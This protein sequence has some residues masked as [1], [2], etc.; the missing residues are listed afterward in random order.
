MI[1]LNTYTFQFNLYDLVLVAT[2]FVGLTLSSQL[3]FKKSTHQPANRLLAMA[4]VITVLQSTWLLV[5][6]AQLITYIPLQVSLAW[7]PLIFCYV[8]K[9]SRPAY[10]FR[11]KDSLH[12]VPLCLQLIAD[13]FGTP[14][15][16]IQLLALA[17]GI[18]YL[19]L[20][21]RLIHRH[22]KGLQFNG[23]D[24]SHAQLKWLNRT[25]AVLLVLGC[26]GLTLAA[27]GHFFYHDGLNLQVYYP[28]YLLWIATMIVFTVKAETMPAA[29]P[30]ALKPLLPAA[31]KQKATWLKQMVREHHYYLDPDLSLT[32]LAEKLE[33][34]VH[35]L[36]RILN[37]V[38]KKSFSD[39][40]NEYRVR[41]V[42]RKMQDT[43]YNHL[44][45]LGIAYESGFNS[46][47]NFTRVLK[48]LTGKSPLDYKNS[49][50]KDYPFYNPDSQRSFATIILNHHQKLNRNFMLRNYFKIA[51]RNLQRHKVFSGFNIFGLATGMACSI[52]IFLWV[53]DESSFDRFNPQAEQIFRVTDQSG[54]QPAYVT[55]PPALAYAIKTQVPAIKNATRIT[56]IQKMI[57][58]GHKKF[59]QKNIFYADSSFLQIFNYPLL[60]GSAATALSAP[61]SVVL[62][63]T[64]AKKYF[65]SA[66]EAMGK[67]IYID[68]DIKGTTLLVTGIL[69]D[70]PANS[71]LQP[72]MLIPMEVYDRVNNVKFGWTNFDVFVYFQLKDGIIASPS[73]MRSVCRQ[74]DAIYKRNNREYVT[75]FSAQPLTDIHLHSHFMR[76]VPGQ[77]NAE[78]VTIF[79]LAAIFIILI[80]CINFINLATAISGQR[81][82]EVGLRKTIGA[83]RP[84]LIAQFMGESLMLSFM[85]LI[86]AIVLVFLLLPL[87]NQLADKNISFDLFRPNILLMLAGVALFT[88]IVSGSY[89]AFFLASFNPVKALKSGQVLRSNKS[90]LRNGLVV[91]QFSISI[92]LIVSTIVIYNQLQFIQHRDIGFDK[93]NLL[94]MRM[95]QVGDLK[96]NKDAMRAALAGYPEVSNF[97][98]TDQ[99]PTNLSDGV[100]SLQW[101]GMNPTTQ[102]EAYRLRVDRNFLGTFGLKV[103]AGRFFSQDFAGDDSSFVVNE[104]ALRVM[105][106]KPSD[107]VGRSI[108]FWDEKA[109]IIGVVKDFNF[110]SVQYG[111]EPLILKSNFSGGYVVMR[112]R[113]G[114]V[115]KV[116]SAIQKSFHNVYGDYPFSYGFVDADIDK[117]YITQ[118][119]M[120]KL[121]N[122]F[123]I[124]SIIISCLGLFGLA[125]FAA[126]QRIKEIGIRKVLGASE[127][128]LVALLS[129]DF[130][131][132]VLLS[133]VFAFPVAWWL[134]NA[135]LHGFAYRITVSWWIFA[136]AGSMAMLIA[137][138]TVSYQAI[139]AAQAKPVRSLRN[140]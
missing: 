76:D 40:I 30:L 55:A 28:L 69:K 29:A 33:M 138:A 94:Y 125:I 1:A 2:V 17:S 80:A 42:S 122:V 107:A 124:L 137:F 27:A 130:I 58:V 20:S 103:V 14:N 79:A 25:M 53:Q 45:L 104:A 11:L 113:A 7:G 61:N 92:I 140:E 18:T 97:T 78:Y 68:N 109:P 126:R 81:A 48:Q 15:L 4:L 12:L 26:L 37:T 91:L 84:Q 6:D 77:G 86:M 41:E 99:L 89:P 83:L 22:N 87:F 136:L 10:K 88:G 110:K 106:L 13:Y 82:K 114:T 71:H 128:S 139:K 131:R 51:W 8:L 46:Q 100:S 49:L 85:A 108:T 96:N 24:R 119:R 39:F 129:K 90:F 21:R 102:V 62:T 95:P 38:L 5:K 19:S 56:D 74:I 50:K 65:G 134:A 72:S 64:T 3:F 115:Q 57:T 135:W 59:D 47:T 121:F 35:E 54:D 67:T 105:Q 111:I 36:S 118:Q 44:T 73:T 43:A 31:L 116:I 127:T 60:T 52:I 120:G 133:F 75:S 117:L 70:I 132:L 98:F 63:E 93:D 123:A 112:T 9:L 34:T 66:A 23:G 16:V 101:P 32:S